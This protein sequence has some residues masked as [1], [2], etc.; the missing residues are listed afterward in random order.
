MSTSHDSRIMLCMVT[1]VHVACWATLR[2]FEYQRCI[3]AMNIRVS[4]AAVHAAFCKESEKRPYV[5]RLSLP[6]DTKFM[7]TINGRS[8]F[9]VQ[10]STPFR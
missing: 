8:S 7:D 3:K 2:P 5:C 9:G 4:R 1:L 6:G 10:M